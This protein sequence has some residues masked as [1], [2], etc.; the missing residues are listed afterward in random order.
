MSIVR[1]LFFV[2]ILASLLA[3]CAATDPADP[4]R[5]FSG[6]P[7]DLRITGEDVALFKTCGDIPR[8]IKEGVTTIIKGDKELENAI[9]SMVLSY[10][11]ETPKTLTYLETRAVTE[12]IGE[13][14]NLKEGASLHQSTFVFTDYASAKTW[15]ENWVNGNA[16]AN[17]FR[18]L[19]GAPVLDRVQTLSGK[20]TIGD[21]STY[22]LLPGQAG[23]IIPELQKDIYAM[24]F[25]RA[26]IGV[27]LYVTSLEKA[28]CS[29]DPGADFL[30]HI[31][32][33]ILS[34]WK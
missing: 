27:F 15:Y 3:A 22:Y 29:L 6:D 11:V 33:Q 30:A 26:N 4:S 25:Y 16:V 8:S 32:R 31:A 24:V 13:P 18:L 7:A 2:L 21:G 17:F 23:N 9:N 28:E 12:F 19:N 10:Q 20:P 34:R 14:I 1:R 5:Y